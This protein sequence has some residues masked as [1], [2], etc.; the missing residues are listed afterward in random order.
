MLRRYIA[1]REKY[2]HERDKTRIAL[3]FEWGTEIL[4]VTSNGDAKEALCRFAA[5]SLRSSDQFFEHAS[6]SKY[7]LDGEIL[8]FPSQIETS[9]TENNTV[10][11]RFF[12]GTSDMAVLVLPQWNCDWEGHVKLCRILQRAG[13]SSLRMSMPYHHFRKPPHLR[14]PEYMASANLGHTIHAARQAVL[15][16]RRAI[17]WLIERGYR[18]IAILGSSLGSCIAFLTFAHDERIDAGIFIH[19]SS[20]FADVVWN[21]LSTSHVR[22]SLEGFV[23]ED[24]LRKVW[25][26]ISPLPFIERLRGTKRRIQAFAG[27]YDQTFL[28]RLSQ[29]AFDEFDR[30]GIPY[31]RRW[32]LCGHYTM[33][34]FPFSAVVVHD[35]VRFLQAE[36]DLRP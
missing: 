35:S 4:G 8:C 1:A 3:P 5:S 20:Y 28:P 10:W 22:R 21:G 11:C 27:R 16:S 36:R 32:L 24:L 7:M 25:S 26:P 14:R 34:E 2:Y 6:T 23:T 12:S 33:A 13:I 30:C 19:V 15:D 9:F 31:K 29:Q 18:K 17:D